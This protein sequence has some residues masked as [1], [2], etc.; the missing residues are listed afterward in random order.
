MCTLN[1]STNEYMIY[2]NSLTINGE[3]YT[4]VYAYVIDICD[5]LSVSI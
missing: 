4:E 3:I 2:E 1:L 5:N